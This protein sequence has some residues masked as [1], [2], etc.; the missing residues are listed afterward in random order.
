M[1][2]EDLTVSLV[3]SVSTL[4]TRRGVNR[5]QSCMKKT[6]GRSVRDKSTYFHTHKMT[7]TPVWSSWQ[8][9]KKRC[10]NKNHKD[11]HHYG[12]RGITYDKRW[13]KF[14]NFYVDMGEKPSK[15]HTLDRIDVNGNY[16]KENCQWAT[17]AMQSKNRRVNKWFKYNGKQYLAVELAEM[18]GIKKRTMIARLFVYKM[19]VKDAIFKGKFPR[20]KRRTNY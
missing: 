2:T 7:N 16:C 6:D 15:L 14:E 10:D 13:K 12:G 18:F 4:L 20:D 17:R 5:G 1:I 19:D 9:M 8:H 3:S 11:Y